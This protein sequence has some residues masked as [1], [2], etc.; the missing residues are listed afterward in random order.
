MTNEKKENT[1]IY[2]IPSTGEFTNDAETAFALAAQDIK[3]YNNYL[4]QAT[5]SDPIVF[6]TD[7]G[8]VVKC[9]RA[10]GKD[11][12]RRIRMFDAG[13]DKIVFEGFVLDAQE[14]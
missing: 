6:K 12:Q 2:F 1:T 3:K 11:F 14:N 9:I 5:I 13:K 4:Y 8:Y 10:N 7:Y